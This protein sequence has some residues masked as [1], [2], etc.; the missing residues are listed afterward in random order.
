MPFEGDQIVV[1]FEKVFNNNIPH[2]FAL[3]DKTIHRIQNDKKKYKDVFWCDFNAEG[4]KLLICYTPHDYCTFNNFNR[5]KVMSS[6]Q[7]I[8][9]QSLY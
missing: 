1:V 5:R 7:N 4:S 6:Y 8:H 9:S 3:N 2:N